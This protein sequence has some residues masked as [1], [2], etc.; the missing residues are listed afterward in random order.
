MKLNDRESRIREA[1][2]KHGRLGCDPDQLD[3]GDSLVDSGLT[4][5]ATMS[6]VIALE[7]AFSV[8]FPDA[9][10]VRSVFES[11]ESIEAALLRLAETVEADGPAGSLTGAG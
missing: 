9:F 3:R 10:L 1:L 4:S 2:R 5:H 7:E 6:V 8:E 11:I